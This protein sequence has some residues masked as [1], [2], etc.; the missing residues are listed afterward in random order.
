MRLHAGHQLARGERL[1]DVV[2][3]AEAQAPDLV[4]I[5]LLGRDHED[6]RVPL[7]PDLPADLEAVRPGQH[8]VQDVEVIVLRERGREPAA[9][10]RLDIHIKPG[11]L[12]IVF[13]QRGYGL[14]I[15][16]DQ[17]SAHFLFLA[18]LPDFLLF[19]FSF[20]ET[21]RSEGAE[22]ASGFSS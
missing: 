3:R 19:F 1:C 6:R 9:A 13:F 7:R 14:L 8:E 18:F 16:D 2:V 5:V 12:Q 15:F 22:T 20:P 17:D 10:V 4:D 11:E 21:A